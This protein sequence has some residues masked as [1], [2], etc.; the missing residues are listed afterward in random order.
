MNILN[1]N[2]AYMQA[3]FNFQGSTD[4]AKELSNSLSGLDAIINKQSNQDIQSKASSIDPQALTNSYAIATFSFSHDTFKVQGSIS[5]IFGKASDIETQRVQGLLATINEKS[6]GY[7]GK[8]LYM[9]DKN[10][11]ASLISEDGFFGIKNTANRI[12]DFV[13]GFAGDDEKLLRQGRSGMLRGFNEAS[14]I[15]GKE[16]PDISQKTMQLALQKVD[17]KL[18]QVGA[19]KIDLKA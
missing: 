5:D 19:N 14:K 7:E 8:P 9:L 4:V 1:F 10:Q 3:N 16:L 11:A 2:S 12:A 13:L 18:S 17:N 15:W 6:I